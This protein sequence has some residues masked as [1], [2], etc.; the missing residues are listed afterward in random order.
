MS[1]WILVAEDERALGE[2]LCDN[3]TLESYH[4]EHVLTGPRALDRMARGGIDLLILDVMLPGCDGF[5]VLRQLRARGDTTPVLVLSARSA[6]QDRIKGLELQA[7]DYL[8]KPFNLRELLLRVDALLR[9]QKPPE[10]GTDVLIFG[11]NRVDFRTMQANC[12]N[13][14]VVPLTATET[15]L[16]KLLAGHANTVVTRK[17][18]VEHLFG[19]TAP[20]TVRTLDN[21]VLRLRKLFEQDSASPR[22]LHTVRGVGF[23]FEP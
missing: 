14:E 10:A 20:R 23:R 18:V 3:L 15:K 6:D 13:G 16:L 22:H 11:G 8:T 7:D 17:V 1:R 12:R 21:I 19:S 5:E 4:A 9:R 2:M